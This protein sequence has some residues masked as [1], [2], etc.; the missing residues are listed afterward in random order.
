GAQYCMW[1]ER[2]SK[3]EYERRF[4]GLK[5]NS[6]HS[7]QAWKLKAKDFWVKFPNK[8]IHGHR[9]KNVSGDYIY[10]SREVKDSYI[11]N[12]SEFCRY[13]LWLI[14]PGNKD[15]YDQTQFG[16]NCERVYEAMSCGKGIY[17]LIGG[18][19]TVESRNIRYAMY[20]YGNCS[21]LLGCI[22][23]RSKKYCILNKQYSKEEYEALRP[24]IIEHMNQMPYEDKAGRKH[25]YGDFFPIE[26]SQFK[27]NETSA[28]EFFPL[29]KEQA[30]AMGYSWKDQADKTHR[31]DIE[32]QDIPDSIQDVTDEILTKILGCVHGGKCQ[33]Q[34]SAAFRI[35][36]QELN[37]YRQ[38]NLPLPDMCPNCRHYNRTSMKNR[39]RLWQRR[40][41]CEGEKSRAG[42]YQ[43]SAKHQHG[44]GHCPNSFQ[45]SYSPD[46]PEIVYC[47][48]CYNAE[49]V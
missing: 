21:D 38:N 12:G 16:E 48:Q 40:C 34:C 27:Y 1:N 23:L 6:R 32:A 33:H 31:A 36:L 3:E 17:D 45:T 37:F 30:L 28:Q 39:P 14:S 46:R 13:C 43:N 18:V 19:N 9:N 49:V 26:T 8:Y 25:Y 22:G 4:A 35:I 29:T 5:P 47:E 10:D 7:L 15:C 24:K 20:C 2:L 42:I 11:I 44:S 41:E